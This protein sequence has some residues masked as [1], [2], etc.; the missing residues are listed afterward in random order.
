MINGYRGSFAS[1]YAT[2][3]SGVP[4]EDEYVAF[5]CGEYEYVLAQGE[6]EQSGNE[7][8]ISDA[9][10]TIYDS[11]GYSS[12]AVQYSP[13]V[14]VKTDDVRVNPSQCMTY[15]TIDGFPRLSQAEVTTLNVNAVGLLLASILGVMVV[16]EIVKAGILGRR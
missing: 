6:V 11:R 8:T 12:G 14:T 15:S 9:K 16:W 2:L 10:C 13:T 4:I 5:R 3:L 7:L 1:Q